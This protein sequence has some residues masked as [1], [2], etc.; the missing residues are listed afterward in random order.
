MAIKITSEMK[1]W[2]NIA[3][4]RHA[5][6]PV[7][8]PSEKSQK[9]VWNLLHHAKVVFVATDTHKYVKLS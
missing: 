6:F 5:S 9:N 2:I 7:G 3:I 1:Q 8:E 4:L